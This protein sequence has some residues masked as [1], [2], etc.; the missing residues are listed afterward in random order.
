MQ[1]KELVMS[2]FEASRTLWTSRMLSVFRI[3]A[4][5]MFFAAGTMKVFGHT[6]PVG[7]LEV[8]GGAAIVLGLFTRPVALVLAGETAMASLVPTVNIDVAVVLYCFLF[9]YLTFVGAGVWSLDALIARRRWV[10]IDRR[11]H[12]A[13]SSRSRFMSITVA[14][15]SR[16]Q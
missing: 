5:L 6:G 3:V 1:G 4:G 7:L 11:D 13:A 14:K 15:V 9:L 2:I 10:R 8:V 16:S 12:A